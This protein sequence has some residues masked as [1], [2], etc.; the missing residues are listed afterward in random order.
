M[1]ETKVG[2][3]KAETSGDTINIDY[4]YK[5]NGR[6]PTMKETI[7]LNTEGYPISFP[8]KAMKL[9]GRTPPDLEMLPWK[10]HSST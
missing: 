3:L 10:L 6:G 9:L 5:N 4:D 7:V 2:Y 1:G 8:L